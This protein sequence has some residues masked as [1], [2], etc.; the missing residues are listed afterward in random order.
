MH[1][2]DAVNQNLRAGQRVR[3]NERANNEDIRGEVGKI[4]GYIEGIVEI[5]GEEYPGSV[6]ITA[7]EIGDRHPQRLTR[8]NSISVKQNRG[9]LAIRGKSGKFDRYSD[10]IVDIDGF[11]HQIVVTS[12][13]LI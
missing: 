4:V 13:D 3:V 10:V 8:G 9:P 12:L 7:L 6:L 11:L 5:E 2:I 1:H